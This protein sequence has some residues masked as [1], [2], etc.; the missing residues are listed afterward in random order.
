MSDFLSYAELR[1]V[2]RSELLARNAQLTVDA[3]DRDGT[4]ANV[5][6]AAMAA[7]G[8]ELTGQLSRVEASLLLGAAR[9]T[10]LDRVAFDR[11][12]ILRKP[13][14]AAVG[15]VNFTT[16]TNTPG[17]FS[18]PSGI[19]LQ[20]ADGVQFLTTEST[21]FPIASMGPITVAVRGMSLS[22]AIS[23]SENGSTLVR[24]TTKTPTRFSCTISGMPSMVRKPATLWPPI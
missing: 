13:A 7:I 18:I 6:V 14:T 24:V 17:S 12:G 19:R 2:A 16:A 20:S 11:Y 3:V 15:S 10:D 21:T 22:S 9:G 8:D 1:D 23:L 5:L 4:D